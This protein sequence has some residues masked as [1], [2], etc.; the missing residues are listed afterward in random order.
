MVG[1]FIDQVHV[2]IQ[3]TLVRKKRRLI[4]QKI[5]QETKVSILGF[6]DE[7]GQSHQRGILIHDRETIFHLEDRNNKWRGEKNE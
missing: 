6:K 1:E 2:E 5:L 4:S 7:T 3:L